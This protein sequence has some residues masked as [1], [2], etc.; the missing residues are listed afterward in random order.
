MAFVYMNN[1]YHVGEEK[2]LKD[3]ISKMIKELKEFNKIEFCQD[4]SLLTLKL[5]KLSATAMLKNS[6]NELF[7]KNDKE[8]LNYL[9]DFYTTSINI[10]KLFYDLDEN[11]NENERL[12]A[13]SQIQ[14]FFSNENY[15]KFLKQIEK[16][17]EKVDFYKLI[18]ENYQVKGIE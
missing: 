7:E 8:F 16:R 18:D 6:D 3:N 13:T 4:S 5:G 14:G 12:S 11:E 2:K 15:F 1:E 10:K 9:D 17:V